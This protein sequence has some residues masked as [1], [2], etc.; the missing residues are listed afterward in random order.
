VKIFLFSLLFCIQ[1]V[2]AKNLTAQEKLADFTQLNLA[3]DSSYGPLKYK[4]EVRGLNLEVVR[5][6]YRNEIVATKT[7]ADFYYSLVRY[8]SEFHDGHFGAVLPTDYMAQ[9]PVVTDWVDGKILIDSVDRT[10]LTEK[11]FPFVKGDEILT[12]DGKPVT[13]VVSNLSQYLGGGFTQSEMR[14]AAQV[15]FVRTGR[16]FPVPTGSV[17]VQIRRGTSDIVENVK[18]EWKNTGTPFDEKI[19]LQGFGQPQLGN[20]PTR[21]DNLS[22]QALTTD[23][24]GQDRIEKLYRCSGT[25]RI[26]IPDDATMIMTKPFV[27][28]YHP[29]AKGN[30]GYLRIPHYFFPNPQEVFRQ[31]EYAVSVLEKNTVGLIIDQDHNCGGSVDFLHSILSLF[32]REPVKPMQFQ[33]LA[34]KSEYFDFKSWLD[35]ITTDT[36]ELKDL[37]KVL[38]FI[39]SAWEK[40]DYLTEKTSIGGEEWVYPNRIQYT[41][42]IVMLIDELSG[43]GGDAFPSLMGGYKRA[44]LLGTRTWGLGGHVADIAPLYNSGINVRITK[45]LFFRPDGV[46]VEN[47]GAVPDINYT[48]TRDDFMYEYKNYQ[49]FYLKALM[50]KLP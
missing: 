1:L 11:D 10:Q 7:N 17:Q 2:Q 33:L 24:L 44:T 4:Q 32:V 35:K 15:L 23:I 40:G 45:S 6:Q 43:S 25:T 47:N 42:P 9:I 29:T 36:I 30:V 14:S 27:A 20:R 3:I 49:K 50:E 18:L 13:D 19:S 48:I 21:F 12:F 46:P 26:H 28:Y 5:N 31:Y 16:R 37:E 8:I 39:K 34:S 38:G 22:I 41:K